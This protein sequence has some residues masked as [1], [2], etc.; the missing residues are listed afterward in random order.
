M[1]VDASSLGIA[2][3]RLTQEGQGTRKIRTL[4]NWQGCSIIVQATTVLQWVDTST[5][6]RRRKIP[7]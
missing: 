5:L 3:A 1:D 4:D 7:R 6:K 2:I